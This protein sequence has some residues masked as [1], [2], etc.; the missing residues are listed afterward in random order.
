MTE[1]TRKSTNSLRRASGSCDEVDVEVGGADEVALVRVARAARRS[2]RPT[3]RA[4]GSTS[5]RSIASK[6]VV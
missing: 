6:S 1:L 5:S 2:A 4:R 3:R